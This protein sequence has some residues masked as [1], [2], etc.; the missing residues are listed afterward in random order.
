M[1][2]SSAANSARNDQLPMRDGQPY[3]QE[4][5]TRMAIRAVKE[6]RVKQ[7]RGIPR[8]PGPSGRALAF[9]TITGRR[10][11]A[12][13]MAE[14]PRD[15]PRIAYMRLRSEHAYVLTDPEVI[16]DLLQTRGRDTIKGR[17][18]QVA[19]SVL[20]DGLL[21]SEGEVHLRQRRM[22]QP[23][24]HKQRIEHYAQE[25]VRCSVEH[26]E[27]W[28][29]GMQVDIATDMSALTLA[30][31]GRALFGSD[32]TGDA[33]EIGDAL[34]QVLG[35]FQRQL[36]PGAAILARLPL[37][38]NRHLAENAE[39]LD[40]MVQRLI[41]EHREAPDNG[42]LLSMMIAAQ[43]DGHGM[44][45]A[46]LRDEAM[47]L[48]LAGHE[49]TAMT[50]TWTWYLLDRNPEAARQ[51]HNEL[52]SVLNGRNPE[53]ADIA[54]LPFT[55]AVIAES[56][57]LYPP[58]WIL[59]R[60]AMSEMRVDNWTLP[61][62]SILLAS[63]YAMHRDPRFW[64]SASSFKPQR[65]INAE[66]HFDESA[67]GQPRG[68]WFPFG[69]G[70]RRCIGDQFAWTEGVLALAT[71]AQRWEAHLVPG[72]VVELMPAVTLR[73]KGGIPMTLHRRNNA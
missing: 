46:Q 38:S 10:T 54:A 55:Y 23:A 47:T 1:A 29:D 28:T 45:D 69:F 60:R 73:P 39:R 15:Y 30:I 6:A 8:P 70:N 66:G 12:A 3:D 35:G 21:T 49:T 27:L 16:M 65:W 52:D 59:G 20:G 50:L 31:V 71:L 62:G 41:T 36:L 7:P 19:K 42:D 68:A 32:L 9:N 22:I 64:D 33:R 48:V 14:I 18:L 26:E 53:F 25:M 72:T 51:L 37:A 40:A 61:R 44:D 13:A 58:A 17:G 57:R 5:R 43:E 11:M 34:T 24:F 67:P 56:M 63:Q 2:T 4:F